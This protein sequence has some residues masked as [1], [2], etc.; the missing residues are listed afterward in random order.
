[1]YVKVYKRTLDFSLSLIALIV[2]SP[3]LFILTIIGAIVFKGNPFFIQPRPGKNEKIFKLIKFRTMSNVKDINGNLLPDSQRL[4][5]YGRILR[6]ISIDELPEIVNILVGDMSIIGPRP[7]LIEY[8][9]YYNEVERHR[10]DIRPGLT[11]LAQVRGRNSVS[12]DHRFALDLE[13]INTVSFSLDVKIFFE[14]VMKVLSHEDVAED[15]RKTEGNFAAI[16][17]QQIK[18]GSFSL[19]QN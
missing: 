11:G 5:K 1:M 7:L 10:H 16:R 18:N 13:Y 12:W 14:T 6:S 3:M 15:T 2:L 4:N 17:E 8:L 9:P 19:S